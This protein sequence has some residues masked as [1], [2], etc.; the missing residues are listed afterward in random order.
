MDN[1]NNIKSILKQQRVF[2]DASYKT[3]IIVQ[4][5]AEQIV[6]SFLEQAQV[7]AEGLEAF[8]TAITE[9]GISRDTIKKNIDDNYDSLQ[10][11]LK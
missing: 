5:H 8:K 10:T 11:F 9:C 6:T 2:F 4:G 3:A 1:S 7:P